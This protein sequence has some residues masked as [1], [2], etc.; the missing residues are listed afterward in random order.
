MGDTFPQVASRDFVVHQTPAHVWNDDPWPTIMMWS[1]FRNLPAQDLTLDAAWEGDDDDIDFPL[2]YVQR[3]AVADLQTFWTHPDLP[4]RVWFHS[5]E[6]Q[7]YIFR[8]A[9]ANLD[10]RTPLGR[11]YKADTA[12][13]YKTRAAQAPHNPSYAHPADIADDDVIIL[14]NDTDIDSD[15]DGDVIVI[16]SNSTRSAVSVQNKRVRTQSK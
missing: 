8:R 5:P 15:S 12:R 10:V 14:D 13:T 11:M 16:G 6:V 7:H 3:N 1:M 2:A 9:V 4:M